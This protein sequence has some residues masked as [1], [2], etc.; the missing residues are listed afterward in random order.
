LS[1]GIGYADVVSRRRSEQAARITAMSVNWVQLAN[2]K[3]EDMTCQ[4]CGEGHR[5]A[6]ADGT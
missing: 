6:G 5:R 3:V 1:E 4:K 2:Q